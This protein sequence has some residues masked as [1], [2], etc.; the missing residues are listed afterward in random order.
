MHQ[1]LT[2]FVA[3]ALFMGALPLV[4]AQ[5]QNGAPAAPLSPN[6]QYEADSKTAKTRFNDD[7][8]LCNADPDSASRMQCKRDAQTEYD[9]S[10]ADAK[11]RLA[12]AGGTPAP[13]HASCTDCG[14]V[15]SVK[16]IEKKGQGS[17]VG[18]VAGGVVGGVLGHQIGGGVGK[19]LA[20]IGGAAGGAYAG[21]AVEKN[22][23]S[24]K[25][26]S[27]AVKYP[28]GST[29]SYEFANEPGFRTGDS[30]R[31]SGNTVVRP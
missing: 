11:S 28:N 12:A 20:T 26:W 30:V 27:V 9:K 4:H 24:S 1:H 22:V 17:G 7:Q 13:V 10:V 15:V 25:V 3:A 21:N 18:M 31:K 16:Q 19:T 2:S 29:T 5:A 6:A 8:K 23:K 14:T